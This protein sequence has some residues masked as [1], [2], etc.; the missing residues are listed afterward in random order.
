MGKK[1]FKAFDLV[2]VVVFAAIVAVFV[3]FQG[4]V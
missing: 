2:W 3:Y 1:V 4:V